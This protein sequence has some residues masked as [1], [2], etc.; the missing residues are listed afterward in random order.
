MFIEDIMLDAE[1]D[2]TFALHQK[3][4]ILVRVNLVLFLINPFLVVFEADCYFLLL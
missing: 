3:T 4:S 2:E 1:F